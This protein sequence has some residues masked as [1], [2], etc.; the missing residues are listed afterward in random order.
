MT[1]DEVRMALHCGEPVKPHCP[2]CEEERAFVEMVERGLAQIRPVRPI[3]PWIRARLRKRSWAP[4]AVAAVVVLS[5]VAMIF[6]LR[7]NPEPVREGQEF[8]GPASVRMRGVDL[9]LESG[10]RANVVNRDVLSITLVQGEASIDAPASAKFELRL[11]STVRPASKSGRFVARFRPDAIV[12]DEGAGKSGDTLLVEG[13]QYALK[14]KPAP[15]ARTLASPAAE[16]RVWEPRGVTFMHGKDWTSTPVRNEVY[17]SAISFYSKELDLYRARRGLYIRF[18]YYAK[19][20]FLF[21]TQNVTRN[22]NYQIEMPD[23]VIGAWTTVTV[24]VL[25]LPPNPGADTGPVREGDV[26]SS[27]TWWSNSELE[28]ADLHLFER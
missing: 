12:I 17:R 21:Q 27:M 24:R 7:R 10:A 20:G 26:F 14:G 16:R 11:Q 8:V 3:A 9:R 6:A 5:V 23:P 2:A 22:N 18:R 1:C 13:Q 25:D 28:I 4:W 15:Q 19:A